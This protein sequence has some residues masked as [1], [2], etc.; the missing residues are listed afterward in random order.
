MSMFSSPPVILR[1]YTASFSDGPH[2]VLL[3]RLFPLVLYRRR[4]SVRIRIPSWIPF[5]GGSSVTVFSVTLKI[6]LERVRASFVT[7]NTAR[8]A[9]VIFLADLSFEFGILWFEPGI[10]VTVDLYLDPN[11]QFITI[12]PREVAVHLTLW[13][14]G[15]TVAN[16]TYRRNLTNYTMTHRM[17]TQPQ[18]I[19]IGPPFNRTITFIPANGRLRTV[20]G[21]LLAEGDLQII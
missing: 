20:N 14:A 5:F 7:G 12:V 3:S 8:P 2:N 18:T 11:F 19:N 21:Y 4:F 15:I 10:T 16:F 9:I 13:I 6:S 1:N 17:N